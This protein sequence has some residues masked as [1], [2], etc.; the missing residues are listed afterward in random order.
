MSISNGYQVISRQLIVAYLRQ[1][2]Q[3]HPWS[4]FVRPRSLPACQA[5]HPPALTYSALE[6]AADID[7]VSSL[8]SH[9]EE[10]QKGVPIL[11]KN[12]LKLGACPLEFQRDPDFSDVLDVL[13]LVD[14]SKTDR[15]SSSATWAGWRRGN[16]DTTAARRGG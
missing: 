12:Y 3:M 10:D 4:R 6:D 1:V 16:R 5:R 8:I 14:L 9:I 11:L 2:E 13:V 15:S 7:G